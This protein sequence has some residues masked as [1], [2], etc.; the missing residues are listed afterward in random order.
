VAR[1]AQFSFLTAGPAFEV[2]LPD[3]FQPLPELSSPLTVNNGYGHRS[4]DFVPAERDT[5]AGAM[6]LLRTF[7]DRD[8]RF[9]ELFERREAPPQWYLRWHLSNGF[10]YTHLREEEG[11]E[12]A[13]RYVANLGIVERDGM[14]PYLLPD[15]PLGVGSSGQPGY[16]DI[17]M[18]TSTSRPDWTLVLHRPGFLRRGRVMRSPENSK[19]VLRGGAASNIQATVYSGQ[20]LEG[21]R[22]L[23]NSVVQGLRAK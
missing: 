14:P 20:D 8:G 16:Q 3:D 21:G 5:G 11:P 22:E 6:L 2:S 15:P 12:P 19:V 7:S 23:I 13:E 1:R 4:Y 10:L 18:F 9:V 17:A